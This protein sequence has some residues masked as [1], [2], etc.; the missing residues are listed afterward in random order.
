MT[1][2]EQAIADFENARTELLKS[3]RDSDEWCCKMKI[4]YEKLDKCNELAKEIWDGGGYFE[5][6]EIW[7][8]LKNTNRSCDKL[9]E[10][11]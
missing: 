11:L 5:N 2:N 3:E 10:L 6:K 7:V 8:A 1:K 4:L 9:F